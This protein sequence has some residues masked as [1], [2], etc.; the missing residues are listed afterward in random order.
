LHRSMVVQSVA[1]RKLSRA[2]RLQFFLQV[3]DRLV[4]R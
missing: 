4:I 3:I 2:S 1:T